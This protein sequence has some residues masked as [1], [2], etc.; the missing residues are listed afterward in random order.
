MAERVRSYLDYNATAPLR[1]EVA[2]AVA[3]ALALV[4]NPSSI[5]A[6]GRAARAAIEAAREKVARLVGAEPKNVIFTS[7]GT[8]AANAVLSPSLHRLGDEAELSC[9]L[10]GAAEHPCVLEGH[11]FGEAIERIPVN[12]EGIVDLG[13]LEA[14]LERAAGERLLVSIQ[15]ANNETGVLQPVAEAAR[16]VREHDGLIHA[17]AVQAAGKIPLDMAALGADVLTLSAHKLGGP[18]GVGAIVLASDQISLGERLIRGGGQERG[19]RAGTENVAGIVGFGVAAEIAARDLEREAGR[20][21]RLRQAFEAELRRI[22]P[23]MVIFGTSVERLPN[24]LAF[25]IPGV[26]AETA[27]IAFD[28]DGLAV[29]SGS[30]CSSGKVRRSHVLEAMGVP[31]PLAEGAIRV[32]LGWNSSEEDVKLFAAACER[33]VASLY[34]LRATA[35]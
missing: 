31:S 1:P 2:E 18:K 19:Y 3:R 6:E 27:L 13:W 16:L 30:A 8:E 26:R 21:A 17:D 33:L 22:A 4:G 32:S 15:T 29:S 12:H 9:L 5:H 35:A 14:R 34:K 11:R 25:A 10:A 20:L 28:L 24:T 7:G 23:D